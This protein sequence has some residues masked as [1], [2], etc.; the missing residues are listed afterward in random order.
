MRRFLI[1]VDGV[2]YGPFVRIRVSQQLRAKDG[3][4]LSIPIQTFFPVETFSP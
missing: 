2:L 4:P 1:R 3:E